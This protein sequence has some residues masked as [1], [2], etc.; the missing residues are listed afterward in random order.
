MSFRVQYLPFALVGLVFGTTIITFYL[1]YVKYEHVTYMLPY[2][3]DTGTYPPESCIFGQALNLASILII[4]AIYLK[5]LQV[6]EMHQ[7]HHIEEK[8]HLNKIT[9]A[10]GVMAGVG[11][12][13]VANFQETNCF[14]IHWTGAILTFGGGAIYLCLQSL[15]YMNIS[16]VIGQRKT[17]MFRIVL[18]IIALLSCVIFIAAAFVAYG[19][20]EGDDMTK[21]KQTDGGYEA[22]QI[23]TNAEWVCATSIMIFVS[24]FYEEFKNIIVNPVT[25]AIIEEPSDKI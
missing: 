2:I 18:A 25:I 23:S 13:V 17:T 5:Y 21:W 4:F 6:N 16:P 9:A 22:H 20:F 8:Y 15:L 10:F 7:K 3:S 24:L 11:V 12:N 19:N 14:A 1:S